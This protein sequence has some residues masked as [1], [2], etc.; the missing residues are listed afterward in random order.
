MSMPS[1]GTDFARAAYNKFINSISTIYASQAIDG[2][3]PVFWTDRVES[4]DGTAASFA[5]NSNSTLTALEPKKSYYFILRDTT[6]IPLTIPEIGGPLPGFQNPNYLPKI[7]ITKESSTSSSSSSSNSTTNTNNNSTNNSILTGGSP[8]IYSISSVQS[9]SATYK[10]LN[11]TNKNKYSFVVNFEKLQPYEKYVYKFKPVSADWPTTITP[12]SG[13]IS[14]SEDTATINATMTFCFASGL[15]ENA[16]NFLDYSLEGIAIDF[17][18]TLYSTIQV[19][20]EPIT[21]DGIEVLSNHYTFECQDCI[22]ELGVG[23]PVADDVI[24]LEGEGNYCTDIIANLTGTIAGVTYNYSFNSYAANWPSVIIPQT[25]Q[26]KASRDNAEIKAKLAFCP[27]TIICSGNTP[28]LLEYS[29]DESMYLFNTE[30]SVDGN[31]KYVSL[32]VDVYPV[33]LPVNLP[34]VQSENLTVNCKDCLGSVSAPTISIGIPPVITKTNIANVSLVAGGSIEY[35]IEVQNAA[36]SN[37]I[38]QRSIDNGQSWTDVGSGLSFNS[39]SLNV[40]NNQN[41]FRAVVTNESGQAISNVGEV[42]VSEPAPDD[43]N[44][45]S[46]GDSSN[47]DGNTDTTTNVNTNTNTS[48]NMADN[49]DGS[50]GSTVWDYDGNLGQ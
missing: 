5:P 39:G 22:P 21:Y 8:T 13:I 4:N 34:T 16:S 29:V 23:F 24:N 6:N 50:T 19:S 33:D 17:T 26:F 40:D 45:D 25:G 44:Q 38:W 48:S 10:I 12:F 36:S 43:A 15:C 28:G 35:K 27:S 9:E 46:T 3:I 31:T 2:E 42:S 47:T 49:T 41:R 20:L 11:Q 30:C 1:F 14:A 32:N 7:T 18:D 37:V